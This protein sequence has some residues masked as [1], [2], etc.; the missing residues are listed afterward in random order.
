[1]QG[2]ATRRAVF[3]LCRMKATTPSIGSSRRGV[4]PTIKVSNTVSVNGSVMTENPVE[5]GTRPPVSE[6][7]VIS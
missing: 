2:P 4:A 5:Q 6:R 3:R 1:M 7:S